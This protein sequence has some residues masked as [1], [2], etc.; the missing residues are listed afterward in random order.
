[1]FGKI[2]IGEGGEGGVPGVSPVDLT[3]C[4]CLGAFGLSGYC[5]KVVLVTLWLVSWIDLATHARW[6]FRKIWTFLTVTMVTHDVVYRLSST[7]LLNATYLIQDQW[8]LCSVTLSYLNHVII[9]ALTFRSGHD[10]TGGSV[11]VAIM[12]KYIKRTSLCASKL[13]GS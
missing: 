13:E 7:A 1:M 12:N 10:I 9:I 5:E 11:H 8:S 2:F 4:L 3:Y 6:Q